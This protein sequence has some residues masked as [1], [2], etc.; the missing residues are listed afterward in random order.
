VFG[1]DSMLYHMPLD[2]S[3]PATTFVVLDK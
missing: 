3:A 1:D 2:G